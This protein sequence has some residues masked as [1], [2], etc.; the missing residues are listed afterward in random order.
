MSTKRKPRKRKKNN[1]NA[2]IALA[3]VLVALLT[4]MLVAVVSQITYKPDQM[5]P[6]PKVTLPSDTSDDTNDNTKTDENTGT[7]APPVEY[8]NLRKDEYYNF[9]VV[10]KDAAAL[11]TD[12]IMVISYDV[13]NAEIALMQIPRDTY[14]TIDGVSCKI[15]AVFATMYNRALRAGS[16]DPMADGMQGFADLISYDWDLLIDYYALVDLEGFRNIVDIIGGVRI[17]I[18]SDMEYYDPIQDLKIELKAGTQILDG[19]K[20]EQF[21]RFREG[22]VTADI[23][24]MDA[25]KMFMSAFLA[26]VKSNLTLAKIPSIMKAIFENVETSV[27]LRDCV[28]FAQNLFSDVDLSSIKMM[29][30]PGEATREFGD[31][32]SWY[33]VIYRSAVLDMIN[34]YFCA[35]ENPIGDESFDV[36][37]AFTDTSNSILQ[38]IYSTESNKT[39]DESASSAEDINKEAIYIPR[40]D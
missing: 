19:E 13:K 1:K 22:Y 14:V 9:L 17:D 24:R 2:K 8:Q 11:N 26:Q 29:T 40:I 4:I 28:Y 37:Y 35:Y 21:V 23:G 15:N 6:N 18:Q 34:E 31:S 38:K 7:S 33:Y 27:S 32:G 5:N 12:V 25:Q 3:T 20:A 10:G 36:N 16:S 30:A 39:A